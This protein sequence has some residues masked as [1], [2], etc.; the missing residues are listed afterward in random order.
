MEYVLVGFISAYF[1]FLPPGML[2]L[3]TVKISISEG[4]ISSFLFGLGAA[5]TIAIQG[6]IA[7]FVFQLLNNDSSIIETL[8][9]LAI[10]VLL[11]LAYYFF[12]LSRAKQSEGRSLLF[13]SNYL[14]GLVMA[15]FNLIAVPYFVGILIAREMRFD[16]VSTFLFGIGV[17]S[18]AVTLFSTYNFLSD[19]ILSRI[20]VIA[21][22]INLILS[23]LFVVLA[24]VLIIQ[25]FQ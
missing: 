25:K 15:T 16:L 24:F 8:K 5:S 19:F 7:T 10:G 18:G 3:I 13:K 23:I 22:N 21:R 9:S 20:G 17:L 12:R 2:N 1:G 14:S 6:M 4:R 11:L